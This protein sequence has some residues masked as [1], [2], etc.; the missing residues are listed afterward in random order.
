MSQRFKGEEKVGAIVSEFPGASN[1]F[2][3]VRIDFCCGG[4]LTLKEAIGKRKLDEKEVL[5]RLNEAYD[6]W[7][8]K[9]NADGV[10]WRIAPIGE[11]IGHIVDRHHGYLRTELPLLSEFVTKI[12][13]VHGASHH[14]L[15][16]LHKLFHQMKIEL[17]QHLIAEEE[18]L[19]PL[20]MEYAS[21]PTAELHERAMN[22]LRQLESD[23]SLVGDYLKEMRAATNGYVLPPD[24]CKTYTLTYRKLDEMETDIF[25]H[26]HLENNILFPR[27]EERKVS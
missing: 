21:H 15:A 5:D 18:T 20:L 25:E 6:V 9:S 24:A 11:L 3:Q 22:G 19:F 2:K 12:L 7:L 17:D 26:I 27:I 16:T 14:E 13:R 10:D 4:D 23:H 1:L 8:N